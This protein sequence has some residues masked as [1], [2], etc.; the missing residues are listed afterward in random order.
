MSKDISRRSFLKGAAASVASVAAMGLVG[1]PVLASAEEAWDVETEVLVVGA[2]GTGVC[3]AAEA[4]GAGA[5]VLVLEKA[6]L[7]GG[8]TNLSG[9][10]MQAAGTKYQKEFTKY[11]DDTPENHAAVWIKEGEGLVDEEL[12]KDLA[13]G[14]PDHIDWLA[15]TCGIKWTSIYGHCHIPYV[16]DEIMADR[17]HVYENGG[18]SGGGVIY[19]QAVWKVCQ[20]RGVEILMNTEATKLIQDENGVVVGVVAVQ[21]GKECRIKATKGV[22]LCTASVDQNRE[23]AKRLN[24]QMYY[25]LDNGVCLSVSTDTGDGIRMGMEIGAD[26]AGFGGC[27]DFCGKTGFG[28]DNRTP[29]FPSFI[30][31]QQGLRFVCED[32]TYAY[33]YRA[34]YQQSVALDGHTYMIFGTSSVTSSEAVASGYAPWPD[35]ETA[36]AEVEAGTLFK[37]ETIEELAE[38]IGVPAANLKLQLDLWNSNAEAGEDPQF[39]RKT[40]IEPITGP[41]YAY[42]NVAYNLGALGGLRINTNAE[43][44]DVNGNVIPHLYAGGL[45]AGGWIGPYYPGSGTALIGTVHWGRKAGAAAAAN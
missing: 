20:E 23:L 13:N 19:V 31:N 37:G 41:F 29:N 16:E 44:L 45:N 6:G 27:I 35:V 3:A 24:P 5:K 14:A 11:Q 38:A 15:D 10:V 22:I 8:S 33:H 40:G 2:G 25:D 4:A 12:V 34:I 32:T 1:A 26:V 39:G 28:T 43:V 36:D 17:I 9:G 18:A 42:Q 7:I 30:V 21:D